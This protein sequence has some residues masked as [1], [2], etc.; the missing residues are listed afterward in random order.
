MSDS[1]SHTDELAPS[2]TD[3]LAPSKIIEE[4]VLEQSVLDSFARRLA[5]KIKATFSSGERQRRY[6]PRKSI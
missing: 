3:E 2:H 4:C 6:G 5:M 1:S